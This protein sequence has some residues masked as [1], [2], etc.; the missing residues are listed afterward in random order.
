MKQVYGE[1]GEQVRK[2]DR[3]AK[4]QSNESLQN[5]LIE[6]PISGVIVRR[7]VQVGEATGDAPLY[8]ITD[9]SKVWVELDVFDKDLSRVKN[10][11]AVLIETLS[12]TSVVGK[13][14]WLSPLASHASQSI[15]ARVILDNNNHQFK[16]GQFV[17]G[18]VT[19]GEYAAPIAVRKSAIQTFRDFQVV[20]A[21]FK[22]TY[23][24]RMLELGRSDHDRVEVL[25]G[26]KPDTD[27]VTEHSYLIKADIEKSGAT[28]DH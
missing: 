27:Y 26:L 4:I 5:Y 12:G 23:E 1:L 25:G 10:G 6:A 20:F 17:R 16:P 19:I 7:D 21:R 2:G 28:H 11:Q 22:D 15:Q 3:L 9:L 14:T 8:T 13:I 18:Q 24:V